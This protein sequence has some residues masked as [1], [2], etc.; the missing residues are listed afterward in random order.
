MNTAPPGL[1]AKLGCKSIAIPL[2]ASGTCSFSKELALGLAL[3]GHVLVPSSRR[4]RIIEYCVTK[5][6]D[7]DKTNTLLF[8]C[9]EKCFGEDRD[10]KKSRSLNCRRFGDKLP[11]P[12]LYTMGKHKG[13][14]VPLGCKLIWR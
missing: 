7:I 5:G 2:L 8:D 12:M 14:T 9:G 4:E 11:P 13:K 6:Y 1:A 10:E 3:A